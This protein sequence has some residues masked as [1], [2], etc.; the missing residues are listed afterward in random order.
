LVNSIGGPG[1]K[2][3]KK[4]Q[5]LLSSQVKKIEAWQAKQIIQQLKAKKLLQKEINQ[6][7][8]T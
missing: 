8:E 4:A 1:L 5:K 2:P 6:V 7:M 3:V